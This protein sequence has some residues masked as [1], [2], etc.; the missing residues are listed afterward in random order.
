[1]SLED[2]IKN[3]YLCPLKFTILETY[4]KDSRQI[5]DPMKNKR[6]HFLYNE[7]VAELYA[8]IANASWNVNKHCTLIL[9]E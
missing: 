8:K 2:A 7:N 1:M 9:V 3:G 6:T 4:S 5:K